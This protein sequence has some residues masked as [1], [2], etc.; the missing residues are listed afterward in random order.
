[1]SLLLR[2]LILCLFALVTV[3]TLSTLAHAGDEWLPV[4]PEELKMTSEPK[5]P[6]AM[7][8]YLYRQVDRDDANYKE[9]T[10]AR[11]KIFS[12]EGRKYADIE[13]P[14]IKGWGNVKN[15]QARTIHSDGSI[16]NFDGKVFEKMVIKARGVKFLAKT[17]T[18]PDVQPGSI[19]E[20]RYLRINPEGRI[21]DSRWLLSE[22]LF[23]KRAKFSLRQ[24]SFFGLQWSWPRGLPP[25][26]LPPVMDHRVVRLETQDI[27]AFQIEDYMPPQDE[28][29]YRVDFR[30][31]RN[32]EKD[33]E[34]FW[35]EESKKLYGEIDSFTD[36]RKAM[37]QAVSQIVSPA[38]TPEQKLRKIYARCQTIRNMTYERE[39][40]EQELN[41]EKLQQVFNVEDIWKRG[42]GSAWTINWLFLAL[43]R[44]AGFEAS[45]VLVSTRDQ[46]I[47]NPTFMNPSDLNTNVVVVKLDGK[48]LYLDPGVAFAPFG[49]LPWT[50]SGAEGLRLEKEGGT[51]IT[52]KIPDPA[53]SGIERQA[54]LQLD[55]SGSMEGKVTVTFR[56]I[57]ALVRRIDEFEVDDAGRKK[58]LED[59]LKSYIAVSAETE[60][61]NVPDWRSSSNTLVTEF[62]MKIPGWASAAG[63]RTLLG[64]SVFSGGEKHVFEG[65]NRVHPIFLSYPFTDVDTVTISLPPGWQISNLPQPQNVDVK[66]CTYALTAEIKDG[67][68]HV[69]RN[70]MVN[71]GFV[72]A[73]YYP[74]VRNFF[75][76]VRSGDEQ[77]VLLSSASASQ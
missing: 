70:L 16:V 65:A 2:T 73:K 52:T 39:K 64:A 75:Q 3:P 12:E 5:A 77:Q 26:T 44:A 46:H 41:R 61:T 43:A 74:A 59:E 63:R 29:K 56:G 76:K 51:W 40:S 48:D 71:L 19:V 62:Q 10:Y 30:Y 13:I 66:A 27:P 49:L 28:L 33:P 23:T 55:E 54:A 38:D 50:E 34:K 18:M 22:A 6:G 36:K 69:S 53:L 42:Y 72:D 17:F 31:I 7:A 57:S 60:L 32:P 1:M 14:F 37:E 47:F 4:M 15:I 11:I 9:N 24:N 21:F 35:K 8:I 45:P 67:S 58:F 68:V 25:G 20:Y